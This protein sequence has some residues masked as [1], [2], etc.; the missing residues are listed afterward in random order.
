MRIAIPND[1]LIEPLV[2]HHDWVCSDRGWHVVHAAASDCADMLFTNRADITLMTP[3][4]YG[5][6]AGVVDFTIVPVSCVALGDFTN[7]MGISFPSNIAYIK[8]IGSDNPT[9]YLVNIGAIVLRERFEAEAVSIEQ[10]QPGTI[11]SVSTGLPVDCVI[12]SP[13]NSSGLALLDVS[14]EFFDL[15]EAPLPVWMWVCR[16][17]TYQ[18][19]IPEALLAMANASITEQSI[20]EPLAVDSDALSREGKIL[21]RWTDVVE[22]GLQAVLNLLYFHQFLSVLPDIKF[23]DN[24]Q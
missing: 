15:A 5:R 8:T 7:Q 16:A 11:H 4:D 14:E 17:D 2:S 10:I 18:P 1:A 3:L 24:A 13:T 21:Y 20:H 9:D 22:E 23:A 19:D 6:A 12:A